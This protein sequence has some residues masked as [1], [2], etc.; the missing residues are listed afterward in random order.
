MKNG[1]GTFFSAS[2]QV[3]KYA[4][5]IFL[6]ILVFITGYM[7]AGGLSA[8][9]AATTITSD[10]NASV[11]ITKS[12][13]FYTDPNVLFKESIP[14]TNVNP[15]SRYNYPDGRAENDGKSDIGL[16]VIANSNTTWYLK[17]K[18]VDAAGDL[19]SKGNLAVYMGQPINRNTGG[20]SDGTLGQPKDWFIIS[21]IYHTLYTSAGADNNN[22]PFG[23]LITLSFKV[24][25]SGLKPGPHVAVI[26]YT[27][28]DSP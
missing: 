23:T 15:E 13:E 17:I 28:T 3:K 8:A 26:T 14:F 10:V 6:L 7:G 9:R 22:T 5:P 27:L 20:T 11:N 24:D 16:V 2:N 18:A 4:C 19:V 1:T 25:G 21:A 12:F